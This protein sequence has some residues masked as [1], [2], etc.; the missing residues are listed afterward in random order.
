M[1]QFPSRDQWFHPDSNLVAAFVFER[2]I[3][4]SEIV[5][6]FLKD[7]KRNRGSS[8]DHDIIGNLEKKERWP[9]SLLSESTWSYTDNWLWRCSGA[10]FSG[11]F[12][13]R[14]CPAALSQ[15]VAFSHLET[16]HLESCLFILRSLINA[17]EGR[18]D[19]SCRLNISGV[20]R[21]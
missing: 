16:Q 20:R 19:A 4:A 15:E 9:Q 6:L 13:T 5:T 7:L 21:G 12:S 2:L 8:L 1:T 18:C 14:P 17:S 3:L 11:L 10:V